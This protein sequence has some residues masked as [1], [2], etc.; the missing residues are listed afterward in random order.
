MHLNHLKFTS[1]VLDPAGMGW[2][3]E[4]SMSMYYT[5]LGSPFHFNIKI[6]ATSL[7]VDTNRTSWAQAEMN[8]KS[9]NTPPPPG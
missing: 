5:L 7:T 9:R 2:S 3:S 4:T 1:L 8:Q 6:K